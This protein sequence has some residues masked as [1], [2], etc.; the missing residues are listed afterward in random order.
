MKKKEELFF[1][2]LIQSL[3]LLAAEYDTQVKSLPDFVHVPDEL[4]LIYDD[5]FRI[6]DQLIDA[7]LVNKQQSAKLKELDKILDKMSGGKI[8][9]QLNTT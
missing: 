1:E 4:V 2:Q 8:S 9:C 3:Q 7:G 6:V 5:C